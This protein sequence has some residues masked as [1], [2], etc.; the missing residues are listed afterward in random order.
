MK[1][2]SPSGLIYDNS[3]VWSK[4]SFMFA[5]TSYWSA[6]NTFAN[7]VVKS[8]VKGM[9]FNYDKDYQMEVLKKDKTREHL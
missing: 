3:G 2:E 5:H 8:L 6:R 9:R 4:R 7:A 1:F